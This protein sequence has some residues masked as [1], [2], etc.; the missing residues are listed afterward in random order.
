MLVASGMCARRCARC[1]RVL[2]PGWERR[3]CDRCLADVRARMERRRTR[4][5]AEGLCTCGCGL[6]TDTGGRHPDCEAEE[7]A[8]RKVK[9][10]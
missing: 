3:T 7:R 9:G 10:K 5:I 6:K 4:L 1:E 8:V 2:A